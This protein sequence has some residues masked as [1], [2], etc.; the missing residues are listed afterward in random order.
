MRTASV[1]TENYA[2]KEKLLVDLATLGYGVMP[3]DAE[4]VDIIIMDYRRFKEISDIDLSGTAVLVLYDV[5]EDGSE[6]VLA[7]ADDILLTP[8][9][10]SELELRLRLILARQGSPEDELVQDKNILCV[11]GMTIDFENY[12]VTIDGSPLDLTFKEYELLKCL[13][14]HRGRV[15]TRDQLLSSVW[16]Y[17]YYGGARTV[18][19]HVRRLRAK[20]GRRESFIETIRNVGYRFKK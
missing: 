1:I 11:D 17:D 13:I 6:D 5:S 20:L 16:G 8:Y 18:D 19:V 10:I 2:L 7:R 12:E 3:A 14:S 9:N 4:A 15:Y